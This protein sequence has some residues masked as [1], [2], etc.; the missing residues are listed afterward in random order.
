[1]EV[2]ARATTNSKTGIL[3]EF[4]TKLLA[5]EPRCP[6][7]NSKGARLY[8]CLM[9]GQAGIHLS[10]EASAAVCDMHRDRAKARCTA[11]FRAIHFLALAGT[12][13]RREQY[14]V[15]RG[16]QLIGADE[17][18]RLKKPVENGDAIPGTVSSLV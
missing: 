5:F 8:T 14:V 10:S 17:E 7:L 13:S 2:R 11:A 12:E 18:R 16:P 1:M 15:S 4:I 6:F 9:S 3:R